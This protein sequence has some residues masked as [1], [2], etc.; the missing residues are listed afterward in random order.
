V[1][2]CCLLDCNFPLKLKKTF[3]T[4]WRLFSILNGESLTFWRT[5]KFKMYSGGP[6]WKPPI[7]PFSQYGMPPSDDEDDFKEQENEITNFKPIGS[8][9][10]QF[11]IENQEI[12]EK[13]K[14]APSSGQ[15]SEEKENDKK[16]PKSFRN[17]FDSALNT[18]SPVRDLI[19]DLMALCLEQVI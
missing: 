6:W 4:R 3:S 17:E 18:L 1:E 8:K 11:G 16:M 15:P 5:K 7:L 13:S 10:N 9:T 14:W 12:E 2:K 19:G